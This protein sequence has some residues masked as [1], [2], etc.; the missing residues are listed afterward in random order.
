MKQRG[1]QGLLFFEKLE[2]SGFLMDLK[3]A[4][5]ALASRSRMHYRLHIIFGER[6]HL[7]KNTKCSETLGSRAIIQGLSRKVGGAKA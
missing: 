5:G 4:L 7:K 3:D 1:A 2:Y 6:N